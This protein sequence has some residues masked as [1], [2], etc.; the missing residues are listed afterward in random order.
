[1]PA[2]FTYTHDLGDEFKPRFTFKA[3]APVPFKSSAGRDAIAQRIQLR[4]K[5]AGG[6][7]EIYDVD[8]ETPRFTNGEYPIGGTRADQ[9][10]RVIA[11][12]HHA[13]LRAVLNEAGWGTALLIDRLV[14]APLGIW[15]GAL[16]EIL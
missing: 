5:P 6:H 8:E 9:F 14:T 15:S 3:Q 1:M 7:L 11:S 4:Y 13:V 10:G 16:K 2:G 12:W